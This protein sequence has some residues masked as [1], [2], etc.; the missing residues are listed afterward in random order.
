MK[1]EN[2][3]RPTDDNIG[4]ISLFVLPC[5]TR[6]ELHTIE[7]DRILAVSSYSRCCLMNIYIDGIAENIDGIA[8]NID[9]NHLLYVDS[10]GNH[11]KT[12]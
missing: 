6:L 2:R 1:I 3:W 7:Y 11:T 8:E 12:D 5:L 9:R 10:Y 4:S